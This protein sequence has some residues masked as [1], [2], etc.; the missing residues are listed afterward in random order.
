MNQLHSRLS[1]MATS[2]P[3]G[4]LAPA[5]RFE[6][7]VKDVN[8]LDLTADQKSKIGA[9]VQQTETSKSEYIGAM[10]KIMQTLTDAQRGQLRQMR[11]AEEPTSQ[12]AGQNPEGRMHRHR[13]QQQPTAP[14]AD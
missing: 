11:A 3:A 7:F 12:P 8:K 5:E 2:R 14:A 10:R 9:I 4:N 1:Q 6:Q 13:G